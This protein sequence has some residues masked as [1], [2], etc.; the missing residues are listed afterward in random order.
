MDTTFQRARSDEQRE[1]RRLAILGTVAAMLT[2]MPVTAI[3]LN[4]LSRRAGLAKSNVL[5]YFESREA[6]LLELLDSEWKQWLAALPAQLDGVADGPSLA[7]ALT[8]SLRSRRVLCD[9]LSAQAGVLERN[10]SA[11]V[12]ARYKRA[13]LADVTA[14]AA[15]FRKTLPQLTAPAAEQLCAAAVMVIGAV[16]THSQPSTGMLAAYREDPSLATFK[17]EFAPS[18]RGVLEL[19]ITGALRTS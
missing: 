17:M 10:V 6:I 13:A 16:W 3:S 18:L 2:E 12:A 11:D 9:L 14:L 1:A 7:V 8:D 15:L 5:R 19:L 4:E